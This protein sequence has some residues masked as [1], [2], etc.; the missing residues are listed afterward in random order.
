MKTE[1][2][3]YGWNGFQNFIF[4]GGWI[5]ILV[6]LGVISSFLIGTII[7]TQEYNESLKKNPKIERIEIK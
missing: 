7:K 3:Q 1:K 6:F 2:Y 5:L 4:G